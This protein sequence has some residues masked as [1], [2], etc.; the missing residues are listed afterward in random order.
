MASVRDRS[1]VE[2]FARELAGMVGAEVDDVRVEV[3]RAAS[4][5]KSARRPG[6][7]DRRSASAEPEPQTPSN[8]PDPRRAP[9]HHRARRAEAG[10]SASGCDRR[11]C[12]PISRPRTS[13]TR[14]TRRSSPACPA[15][16]VLLTR[17]RPRPCRMRSGCPPSRRCSRLCGSSSLHVTGEPDERVA[18]AYVVRLRELTALRRIEQIKSQAAA[19]QSGDRG[20][21]VQPDVR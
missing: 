1:K 3:R 19:H 20:D 5:P 4:R 11:Q 18:A 9:L 8:V 10:A 2:A 16:A 21:R 6:T 14:T 12:G 13:R 7:H 15:S 17:R